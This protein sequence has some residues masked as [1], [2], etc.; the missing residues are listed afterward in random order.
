MCLIII[1]VMIPAMIPNHKRP[2]PLKPPMVIIDP[3]AIQIQKPT[4]TIAFKPLPIFIA[5]RLIHF[6]K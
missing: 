4:F 6:Q 3:I 1:G 5:I 2:L